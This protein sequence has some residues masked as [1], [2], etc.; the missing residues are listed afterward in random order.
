MTREELAAQL[1]S[2]ALHAGAPGLRYARDL[3]AY[4]AAAIRVEA[5]KEILE[6]IAIATAKAIVMIEGRN[7][8]QRP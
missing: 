8:E 1:E 3:L 7:Q 2:L 5:E 6:A 4:T